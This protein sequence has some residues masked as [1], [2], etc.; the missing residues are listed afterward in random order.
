LASAQL[1]DGPAACQYR[2]V[3][4]GEANPTI[5]AGNGDGYVTIAV[6]VKGSTAGGAPSGIHPV[7]IEWNHF[8]AGSSSVALQFPS[9][10]NLLVLGAT[11]GA[12]GTA[13]ITCAG[14]NCSTITGTLG[15]GTNAWQQ[16]SGSPN[17]SNQL[18]YAANATTSATGTLTLALGD[19]QGYGGSSVLYDIAGAATAPFDVSNVSTGNQ[20]SCGTP[21]NLSTTSLTPTAAN[22]L[23]VSWGDQ[24]CGSAKATAVDAN[25][26]QA[27][28]SAPYWPAQDECGGTGAGDTFTLDSQ[29]GHIFYSDTTALTFIWTMSSA[30]GDD[31]TNLA[32]AFKAPAAPSS[33]R[34]R[35]LST[36]W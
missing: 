18:L 12:T 2:V 15:Y 10:G 34:K 13:T 9:S 28:L 32:A 31:W 6:G 5:T 19:T 7:H 8:P 14:T 36:R 29:A 3:T 20:T 23:A 33:A 17:L 4:A 35:V 11:P 26:H 21:C 1:L 30:A 22:G 16:I 27:I 25:G 24:G